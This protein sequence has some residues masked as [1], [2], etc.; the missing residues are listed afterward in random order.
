MDTEPRDDNDR[1]MYLAG[2]LL[3]VIAVAVIV[4]GSGP[5]EGASAEKVVDY[6]DDNK[7][8]Q[9]VA[10]FLGGPAAAAILVFASRLR[11]AIDD[12]ARAARSLLVA[13]AALYAVGIAVSSSVTLATVVASDK[14]FEGT[15]QT[16]NVLNSSLWI[17]FVIGIAVMLIGAGLSVLRTG[18]LPRWLGWV[19]LVVGVVA[20]L[21]PGG[22]LGFLVAPLWMGVA[23]FLLYTRKSAPAQV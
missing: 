1:W 10:V 19:A 17:P 6:F 15:A 4:L 18:L 16:L 5:G 3:L 8:R 23:G 22:F 14:G 20:L 7:A 12:R 21:G 9:M 2:P 13:G 11:A